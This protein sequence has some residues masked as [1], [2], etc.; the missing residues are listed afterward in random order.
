MKIKKHWPWSTSKPLLS[1]LIEVAEPKFILELGI[2]LNSTPIFLNS[3]CKD[4]MFIDNNQRWINHV[5]R[6]NTFKSY[7]KTIFHDLGSEVGI[8]ALPKQLTKVKKTEIK[9]Y[10]NKLLDDISILNKFPR[11]MFVDHFSC[12]RALAINTLYKGFDIIAYHDCEL[13]GVRLYEYYFEEDLETNYS[14][15]TLRTPKS[16]T[17]C[18]IK[19]GS[20]IGDRLK[21]NIKK[22]ILK[23]SK[24]INIDSIYLIKDR[25]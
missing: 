18:F 25:A 10:Y 23:Y 6:K 19:H 9:D 3:N 21:N 22:H 16:W 2:G 4:I 5:K 17:G 13:R 24:E 14:H 12:C 11:L 15:Y 1:S 8:G 20:D 7:H